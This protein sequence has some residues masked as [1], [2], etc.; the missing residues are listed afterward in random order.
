MRT[1]TPASLRRVYVARAVCRPET[2]FVVVTVTLRV[3]L[4]SS[5]GEPVTV[6]VR[7]FLFPAGLRT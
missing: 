7:G 1:L 3:E 2:A 5:V 6:C 4:S